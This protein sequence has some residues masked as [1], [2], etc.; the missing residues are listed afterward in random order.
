MSIMCWKRVLTWGASCL[1]QSLRR[2]GGRESGEG[3]EEDL[4]FES[5]VV[6]SVRESVMEESF[7]WGSVVCSLRMGWLGVG[8]VYVEWK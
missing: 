4:E 7:I 8:C 5:C 6:M 2:I 1:A 3:C